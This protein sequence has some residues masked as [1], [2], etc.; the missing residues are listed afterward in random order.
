MNTIDSTTLKRTM[1]CS[2][3][4]KAY[5][6]SAPGSLPSEGELHKCFEAVVAKLRSISTVHAADLERFTAA[7]QAGNSKE[8]MLQATE[9][10]AL[11]LSD[12]DFDAAMRAG[13]IGFEALSAAANAKFCEA[14]DAMQALINVHGK[15]A[16]LASE[17]QTWLQQAMAYAPAELLQAAHAMVKELGLQPVAQLVDDAGGPVFSADQI[18]DAFGIAEE[19]VP[20]FI[21]EHGD[22]FEVADNVHTVQ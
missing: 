10:L 11:A 21:A 8:Q 22:L 3:A 12:Q 19:D 16:R 13:G 14:V 17:Y 18:A 7:A 20:R 5:Q 6:F 9:P 1:L 15:A 2:L 4:L